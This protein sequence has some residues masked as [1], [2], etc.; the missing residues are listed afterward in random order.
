[1]YFPS[2]RNQGNRA[3]T[4]TGLAKVTNNKLVLPLVRIHGGRDEETQRFPVA[5]LF[6]CERRRVVRNGGC[7]DLRVFRLQL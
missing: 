1:M 3:I 5:Q 2:V 7:T 4:L 6:R